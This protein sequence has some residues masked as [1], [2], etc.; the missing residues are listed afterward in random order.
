MA[1]IAKKDLIEE[2]A[3]VMAACDKNDT[4]SIR[5]CQELRKNFISQRDRISKRYLNEFG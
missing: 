5:K 4:K 1:T 3:F 2:N